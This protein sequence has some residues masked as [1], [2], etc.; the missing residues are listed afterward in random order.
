MAISNHAHS[1]F[2]H[3]PPCQDDWPSPSSTECN[4]KVVLMA[5]S[6]WKSRDL[7]RMY[8]LHLRA[9]GVSDIR[10]QGKPITLPLPDFAILPQV[11]KSVGWNY[12]IRK[13]VLE[14]SSASRGPPSFPRSLKALWSK[15][16]LLGGV[17]Y[18]L[19]Y[20]NDCQ[21]QNTSLFEEQLICI[22]SA[23][24]SRF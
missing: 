14:K 7:I 2:L 12:F 11:V 3:S 8:L 6:P 4:R 13:V 20:A 1:F 24:S 19:P 15:G 17:S 21:F 5:G 23:L 9:P 22:I 10:G 16:I 18:S